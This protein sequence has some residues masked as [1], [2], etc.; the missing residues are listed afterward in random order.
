[1]HEK[2]NPNKV[3]CRIQTS[4]FNQS[5]LICSFDSHYNDCA[6]PLHVDMAIYIN[7]SYLYRRKAYDIEMWSNH[8]PILHVWTRETFETK[9]C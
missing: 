8:K 9:I 3:V 4:I 6:T 5:I 2:K 7:L 1:M